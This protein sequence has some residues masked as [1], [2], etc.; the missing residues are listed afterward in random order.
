[1]SF[2]KQRVLGNWHFMRIVRMCLG[3]WILVMAIQ[4][5]DLASGLLSVFLLY[6]AIAGVGCCGPAGCYVTGGN[7]RDKESKEIDYE[8]IE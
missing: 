3:I 7:G 2:V 8:E 1:M 5:K 6:T 4:S